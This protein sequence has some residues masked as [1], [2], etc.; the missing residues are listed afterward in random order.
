[1]SW[2]WVSRLEEVVVLMALLRMPSCSS[3]VVMAGTSLAHFDSGVCCDMVS[4]SEGTKIAT[5]PEPAPSWALPDAEGEGAFPE[6][7]DAPVD[8]VMASNAPMMPWA[9]CVRRTAMTFVLRIGI[10]VAA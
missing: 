6:H 3:A 7:A 5:V 10:D 4:P 8:N 9:R 2:L 1:M